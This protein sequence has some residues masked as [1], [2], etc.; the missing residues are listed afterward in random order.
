MFPVLSDT[1]PLF[2]RLFSPMVLL[3]RSPPK[4]SLPTPQFQWFTPS[5]YFGVRPELFHIP[6]IVLSLSGF[7]FGHGDR[8]VT[9]LDGRFAVSVLTFSLSSSRSF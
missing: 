1:V 7:F 3:S 2:S 6:H 8:R 9:F 5:L 4:S